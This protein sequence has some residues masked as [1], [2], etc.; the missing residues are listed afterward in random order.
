M[1]STSLSGVTSPACTLRCIAGAP[2]DS[3]PTIRIAGLRPLS[4]S[5]TPEMSPPPPIG[6]TMAGLCRS[7]G[8]ARR[9]AALGA[10]TPRE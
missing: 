4:A 6:T 2:D 3:T 1:Q 9:V 8:L 7:P 10:T 5:E